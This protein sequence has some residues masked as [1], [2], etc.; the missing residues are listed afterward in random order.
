MERLTIFALCLPAAFSI[1][2][3]RIDAQT[4]GPVAQN[5]NAGV[6]V[7]GNLHANNGHPNAAVSHGIAR[8]PVSFAPGTIN[9]HPVGIGGQP[10][11]N[12]PTK[13]SP[14]LRPLNPTLA[15]MS[16]RQGARFYNVRSTED[17]LARNEIA[18]IRPPIA[19]APR[20]PRADN[21]QPITDDS[22]RRDMVETQ[23]NTMD[24]PRAQISQPTS[25]RNLANGSTT[26]HTA[27]W[28][29]RDRNNRF[30]YFDALRRHRHEWH[31]RDWWRQHCNTIVFNSGGYYFLDAGYWYPALGYDP[32]LQLL[33]SGRTD[34]YLRQ[35]VTRSGHR[36][37]SGGIAGGR[38][39]RRSDNWLAQ[40]GD[41]SGPCQ[42][43]TRLRLAHYR[44]N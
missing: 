31:N 29:W 24:T 14:F 18:Q 34:L 23:L 6:A 4:N 16:A 37:R 35:S 21:L 27:R 41:A 13:Y 26:Q 12:P 33:R 19:S 1:A 5:N 32:E 25:L 40:R 10:G 42:F 43:S 28:N 3:P 44:S 20:A 30:G 11:M 17:T 2:A 38:L 8:G 9:S 39:L 7:N 36:E 22:L 15:A